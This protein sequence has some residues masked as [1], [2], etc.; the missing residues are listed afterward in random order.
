[1]LSALCEV[2][3]NM[4]STPQN[5]QSVSLFIIIEY[6]HHPNTKPPTF[7]DGRQVKH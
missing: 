7:L 4:D 3:I 1:M 5:K 2:S 6:I